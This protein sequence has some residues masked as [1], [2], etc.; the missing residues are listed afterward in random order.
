MTAQIIDIKNAKAATTDELKAAL[1]ISTLEQA[2]SELEGLFDVVQQADVEKMT[3]HLGEVGGV[4]AVDDVVRAGS[5]AEFA[6][7]QYDFHIFTGDFT[8]G[9]E[10]SVVATLFLISARR[11][12]L[13]SKKI[14]LVWR[15]VPQIESKDDHD[16]KVT[17]QKFYARC[18]MI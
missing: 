5:K 10:E 16:T 15:V 11:L 14:A 12:A 4:E 13:Q 2:K 1:G 7:G 8:E 3:I 17:V 18:A 6:E 9:D